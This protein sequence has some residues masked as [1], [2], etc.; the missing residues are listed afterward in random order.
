MA[1]VASGWLLE[2]VGFRV[3]EGAAPADDLELLEELVFLHRLGRRIDR[4]VRIALRVCRRRH[5]DQ[6][7]QRQPAGEKAELREELR[8][9]VSSPVVLSANAAA[10]GAAGAAVVAYDA[11][12]SRYAVFQPQAPEP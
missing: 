1:P 8:H 3:R 4:S 10:Q 9:S 7:H 11:M 6:Q 12:V 5:G 2:I